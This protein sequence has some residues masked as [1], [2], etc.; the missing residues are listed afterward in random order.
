MG[1]PWLQVWLCSFVITQPTAWI[2]LP[3]FYIRCC[4]LVKSQSIILLTHSLGTEVSTGIRE[5]ENPLKWSQATV[6]VNGCSSTCVILVKLTSNSVFLSLSQRK[7]IE[8]CAC[9]HFTDDGGES[10]LFGFC[11]STFQ[12]PD[13]Y[14]CSLQ[15]GDILREL[16]LCEFEM[17]QYKNTNKV[18]LHAQNMKY[19]KFTFIPP[20]KTVLNYASF[21]LCNVLQNTSLANQCDW[22]STICQLSVKIYLK[23]LMQSL[24]D[25][26]ILGSLV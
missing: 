10:S 15:W 6:H 9:K 22:G 7:L 13:M 26:G 14:E 25:T 1:A 8:L 2:L 18:L 3:L 17:R 19:N 11:N 12:P 16:S 20:G 5:P 24:N 21:E 23:C 4:P